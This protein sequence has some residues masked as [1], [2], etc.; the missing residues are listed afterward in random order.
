MTTIQ[1]RRGTSA[2]WLAANPVL[3]AGEMGVELQPGVV[4]DRTKIGDGVT[5]WSALPYSFDATSMIPL[6]QRGVANGVATLDGSGFIPLAQLPD[7]AALDA[8]IAA[9]IADLDAATTADIAAA[10]AALAPP[11][12]YV[13][14][15]QPAGAGPY[16]WVQTGLGDSGEDF[17]FWIEDGS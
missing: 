3:A 14:A 1:L 10:I 12:C 8:E 2:E 11:Q 5:T 4:P 13:G 16:L 17:T 7:A 9:A 15:E 6:S